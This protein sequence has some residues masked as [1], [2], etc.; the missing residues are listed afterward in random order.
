MS[1]KRAKKHPAATPGVQRLNEAL[2]SIDERLLLIAEL[3]LSPGFAATGVALDADG[4]VVVLGVFDGAASVAGIRAILDETAGL[5]AASYRELGELASPLHGGDEAADPAALHATFFGRDE[6]LSRRRFD[7]AQRMVIVADEFPESVRRALAWASLLRADVDAFRLMDAAEGG[8]PSERVWSPADRWRFLAGWW[9]RTV[10]DLRQEPKD[11]L[12]EKELPPLVRSAQG[13]V[14]G[15]FARLE[16]LG[17]R[18]AWLAIGSVVLMM[19]GYTFVFSRLLFGQHAGYGTQAFDFGIYDQA[20][21]L[22]SRGLQPFITINGMNVFGDHASPVLLLLA[23]L[24]RVWADARLLIVVQTA[25]LALGALPVYLFAKEKLGGMWSAVAVATCYLLYPALEWVGHDG[26][27]PEALAVPAILFAFLFLYRRK[28]LWFAVFA[29]LALATKE[30][31][32]F[33]VVALG[34]FAVVA[35]HRKVGAVTITGALA[36]LFVAVGVVVPHLGPN[37]PAHFVRDFAYLGQAG[38][39]AQLAGNVF[40]ADSGAYLLKLLLPVALVPLSAPAAALMALPGLLANLT[41][42]DAYHRSIE[43]QY[44]AA[45]IPFV[46][47]AVV[48]GLSRLARNTYSRALVLAV[49]LGAAVAGNYLL[50]PSPFAPRASQGLWAHPTDRSAVMDRAVAM[51]PPN[52]VV[53]ANY[54]VVPHLTHR[55]RVY[56][57]PMPFKVVNWGLAGENAPPTSTVEYV[58]VDYNN[59]EADQLAL[60]MHLK[61]QGFTQVFHD[62]AIVVLKRKH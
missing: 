21:W 33:A 57:F 12:G 53:S 5:R 62:D 7:R 61:N 2:A 27:H 28:W 26:F 19:L 54:T 47:I 52:A 22:L 60:A 4:D 32:A 1:R 49:M 38:A 37:G 48:Y 14:R 8:A 40:S 50:S 44:T 59:A 17:V 46:F 56:V 23:P 39:G 16:A 13:S 45:V 58:L 3:E 41:N 9:G 6:A 25:A 20:V 18:E 15:A 24:Y 29:V 36:W 43:F 51:I 42:G 10:G 55:T 31:A 11:D 35:G 34:A 30:D